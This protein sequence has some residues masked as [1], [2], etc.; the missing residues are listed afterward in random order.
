MAS[1][2][3]VRAAAAAFVLA[4]GAT[5]CGGGGEEASGGSTPRPTVEAA[6]TSLPP[7]VEAPATTSPPPETTT[8]LAPQPEVVEVVMGPSKVTFTYPAG[9]S[10]DLRPAFDQYL[11]FLV[12]GISNGLNPNPSDPAI[13]STSTEDVNHSWRSRVAEARNTGRRYSGEFI[14]V[15]DVRS[16]GASLIELVDC[17]WDLATMVDGRGQIISPPEATPQRTIV[18]MELDGDGVWR[19]SVFYSTRETCSA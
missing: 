19:V 4:L 14:S 8:S 12:A 15:A 3:V 13:D 11:A 18:H 9:L 7:V 16:V 5:A 10:P 2:R 1:R 17:A 6:T